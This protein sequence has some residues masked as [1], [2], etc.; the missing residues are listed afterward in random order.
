MKSFI[1]LV[2]ASAAL[3]GCYYDKAHVSGPKSAASAPAA[4]VAAAPSAIRGTPSV[5]SSVFGKTADGQVVHQFRIVGAG[6][7]VMDVVE[8]GARIRTLFLPDRTGR[9]DDVTLGCNDVAGYEADGGRSLGATIGRFGN[10]IA[11]GKFTLDGK[12]YTLPLNNFPGGVGCS[13]HGGTIGFSGR[14]W[15]GTPIRKGAD[16]GVEFKLSSA[17]GDQGYPGK[18]D[19]TVRYWLTPENVW[20]IEYTATTDKPTVVNLTNHVFFNLK[21]EGRGTINDHVIQILADQTTAVDKGLIPTGALLPVK[22]TPFDFTSPRAIGARVNE[23]ANEQIRFGNGYDHN[24][25]LRNP[26]GKLA[27]ACVLSEP[28]S[29]RTVE[30]WTTQPGLQFYGGNFFNS[31]DPGKYGRPIVYRGGLALETQHYP[32]SPNHANFPSTVLRPGQTFTSTTE[33]RFGVAK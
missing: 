16:V 6:G 22:G 20:R 21:G 7:V 9:L 29:G 2:A 25:V 3:A 11:A 8:Y 19:V 32:D 13:L 15:K 26:S 27:K 30:V 24:W 5:T 31:K 28:A 18:M 33:Y 23:T 12:G 14:V 1:C 10:R 4:S 17:D